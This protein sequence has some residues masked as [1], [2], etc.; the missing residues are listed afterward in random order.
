MT[1]VHP[2]RI[3]Q[4][5]SSYTNLSSITVRFNEPMNKNTVE[6]AF[7]YAISGFVVTS[8]TAVDPPNPQLVTLQLDNSLTAGANYLLE[9]PVSGEQLN[10]L[11]GNSLV[12]TNVPFTAGSDL[13]ALAISLSGNQAVISWPAPSTGF[14][15]QQADAI[16]TPV[17]SIAWTTVGTAPVVVNGRNTVSLTIGPGNKIFRLSQ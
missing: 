1:D 13:P 3:V 5:L 14:M 10:D 17:S 12:H 9:A 16:V 4:V 11:A 7:A 8:A 15:L 6:S 2:P